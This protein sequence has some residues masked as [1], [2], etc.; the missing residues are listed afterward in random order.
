[1]DS[2]KLD[3]FSFERKD[4]S[5]YNPEFSEVVKNQ[6]KIGTISVENSGEISGYNPLPIIA[7]VQNDEGDLLYDLEIK[8]DSPGYIYGYSPFINIPKNTKFTIGINASL[9]GN[10][11][12][13][14]KEGRWEIESYRPLKLSAED[15]E[16]TPSYEFSSNNLK[17][18]LLFKTVFRQ[19][20]KGIMPRD[21]GDFYIERAT[22]IKVIDIL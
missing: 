13:S 10:I 5:K 20:Q 22:P 16:I 11:Y 7:C 6:I 3:D 8:M 2:V 12:L 18:I 1:V 19:T 9:S 14:N 4:L 17:K 15:V 21:C